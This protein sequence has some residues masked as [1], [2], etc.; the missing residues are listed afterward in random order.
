MSNDL[1]QGNCCYVWPNS[2]KNPS[3]GCPHPLHQSLRHSSRK[4]HCYRQAAASPFMNQEKG[5]KKGESTSFT[6]WVSAK[7]KKAKIL[8]T[9]NVKF[10]AYNGLLWSGFYTLGLR[11]QDFGKHCNHTDTIKN[12]VIL[13]SF[14]LLLTCSTTQRLMPVLC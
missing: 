6:L 8:K 5:G 10:T 13:P 1:S 2:D 12:K 4:P 11:C 9:I 14:G 3:Q 7:S